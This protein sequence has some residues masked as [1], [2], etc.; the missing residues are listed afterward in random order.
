VIWNSNL[1]HSNS[2]SRLAT[3]LG[4]FGVILLLCT[5]QGCKENSE[6]PKTTGEKWMVITASSG[7]LVSNNI[8]SVG[9]D[10]SGRKWIGTTDGVS[11]LAKGVWTTFTTVNG[12]SGNRVTAIAPGR[13]GSLWFGTDGSFV[14]RYIEN[15]PQQRWRVYNVSDGVTDG[16]IYSLAIDYYGDAWLGT[17]GGAYQFQE[18]IGSTNHAGVWKNYS[19]NVGLPE[20]RIT[21]VAVD[22]NN[23][24]WFGTAFSGLASYDNSGWQPYPLPQGERLRTTS[25]ATEASGSI[26]IGTWG[27]ALRFDGRNWTV[28]DTTDGLSSNT[29]NSVAVE[30]GKIIW[31][32][33]DRGV[34]RFDGTAWTKYNRANSS[35]VSDT[36]NVVAADPSRNVWFG[37][38][39]GLTVYNESGIQL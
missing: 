20:S 29:V 39:L 10:A 38:P 5:A 32:A 8:L 34:C 6:G 19:T 4:L 16:K 3:N 12:L 2:T 30:A 13:D 24:K 21:A 11:E 25:I 26:W 22:P 33:T 15:D 1:L 17:N 18:T 35:L 31:V 7:G 27:G 36:V 23:T 9:F 28:Y 37:T 14:C